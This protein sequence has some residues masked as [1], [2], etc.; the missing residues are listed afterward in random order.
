[1]YADWI[2]GLPSDCDDNCR[3][4]SVQE[5]VLQLCTLSVRSEITALTT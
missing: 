1:M 3:S 5:Q 4:G 2:R